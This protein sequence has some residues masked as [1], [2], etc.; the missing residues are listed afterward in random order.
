MLKRSLFAL[1]LFPLLGAGCVR[2]NSSVAAEGGILRSANAAE[3]WETRQ[4]VRQEK[5]K[6]ITIGNT[7]ILTLAFDPQDPSRMVIGTNEDGMFQTLNSGESWSSLSLRSGSFPDIDIHPKQ[8]PTLL[9]A[10]NNTI[11]RSEDSGQTWSTI[12]TETTQIPIVDV[13]FDPREPKRLFAMTQ[14]GSFL[15]SED[16][17][18]NW[19]VKS[20]LNLNV[21]ELVLHPA[22]T[23]IL[24]AQTERDGIFKTTDQ[25]LTWTNISKEQLKSF[26]G[27][28]VVNDLKLLPRRPNTLYLATNYGLFRTTDGGFEW[29]SVKTLLPPKTAVH[30]VAIDV[31]NPSTVYFTVGRIIHKTTDGGETWKV[32]ENFPSS[33]LINVLEAH[34]STSEILYAGM[35]KPKK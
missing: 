14:N 35:L 33:R 16:Q 7:N 34:P 24:Y 4:F 26:P 6:Q 32:I 21:V 12:Y 10:S 1:F 23:R 11:L 3:D 15:V 25:G 30:R 13:K 20:R 5:K 17:G 27:A 29:T 18:I 31:N 8:N 28:N 22:D 9:S 19:E 2:L